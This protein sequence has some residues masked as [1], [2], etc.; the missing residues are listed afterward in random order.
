MENLMEKDPQIVCYLLHRRGEPKTITLHLLEKVAKHDERTV[1]ISETM[2]DIFEDCVHSEG[3]TEI[4][5]Q[6][7]KIA[8]ILNPVHEPKEVVR[9]DTAYLMNWCKQKN[10]FSNLV[11]MNIQNLIGELGRPIMSSPDLQCF[12]EILRLNRIVDLLMLLD[13]GIKRYRGHDIHQFNVAAL[14][15]FFLDTHIKDG[16]S[17]EDYLSEFY[18]E[19][20]DEP[21][22]IRKTWLL[23]SLLHDHALPIY[24][25][26][27]ITPHIFQRI[28]GGTRRAGKGRATRDSYLNALRRFRTAL[29]LAYY[30][31]LSDNLSRVYNAFKTDAE[32][33]EEVLKNLVSKEMSRIGLSKFAKN[34]INHGVIGAAN[35]TSRFEGSLDTNVEVL[36]RA[37]G[38]H[39]MKEEPISFRKD[40]ITFLLVAC[41]ELQEWGREVALFPEILMDIPSIKIGG[42]RIEDGKRFFTDSLNVSFRFLKGTKR[43]TR[44]DPTYF[45]EAKERFLENRLKFDAPDVFPKISFQPTATVSNL[46]CKGGAEA[47]PR[48]WAWSS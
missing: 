32:N 2:S 26:F 17:L 25:M 31:L 43:V 21:L 30:D 41:D 44:F 10:L 34:R 37:I 9:V 27:A 18:G 38:M 36:A 15:L 22:D 47:H 5:N 16:R 35:I 42:F 6:V 33:K 48:E 4:A 45:I 24:H 23:S 11:P 12:H 40:P 3:W 19:Q 28:R 7:F 29:E 13:Q 8:S 1:E 46:S 39:D 20:F 14:G